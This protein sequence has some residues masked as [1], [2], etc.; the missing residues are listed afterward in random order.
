[1]GAGYSYPSTTPI[2]FISIKENII[3]NPGK[4]DI[5]TKVMITMFG[6][7]AEIERDLI[8]ERT[9]SGLKV[10]R[11]KGKIL[12]R[13]KGSLGKS[14]LDGKEYEIKEFLRKNVSVTS[15][16]KI[17]EVS[18]TCLYSFIESRKL[19]QSCLEELN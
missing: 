8:S 13:P 1:M 14:K 16:A 12:G 9:K 10:A 7:F 15:I 17:F 2:K 19:H 5:Q 4:Q 18:R 11:E 6:L 3:I